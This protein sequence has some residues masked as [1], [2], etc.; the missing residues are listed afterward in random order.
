MHS[1]FVNL[2][3][4]SHLV[5]GFKMPKIFVHCEFEAEHKKNTFKSY[6]YLEEGSLLV[7][8]ETCATPINRCNNHAQVRREERST[9]T[10]ELNPVI[11]LHN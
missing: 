8:T 11:N 9:Q 4:C 6:M 2:L 1:K 3:S 5:N 7:A 10:L